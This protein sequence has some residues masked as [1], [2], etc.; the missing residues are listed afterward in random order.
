MLAHLRVLVG[1]FGIVEGEGVPN[2]TPIANVAFGVNSCR[3]AT[4]GFSRSDHRLPNI[5]PSATSQ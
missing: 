4:N 1:T 5:N 3:N 2:L